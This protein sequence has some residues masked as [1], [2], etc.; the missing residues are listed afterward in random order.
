MA[1]TVSASAKR[2]LFEPEHQDYRES[3]RK[4]LAKEVQPHYAEWEK[5]R[6]VPRDLFSKAAAHGFLAM[7]IPEAYGGSGVE[8]WRFNVVLAEEA[9]RSDMGDALAGLL[10]HTD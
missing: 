5:A 2:T 8:D 10:L 6:L 9:S 4:F 1:V 3:Y 7:D